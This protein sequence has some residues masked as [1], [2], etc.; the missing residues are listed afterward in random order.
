MKTALINRPKAVPAERAAF[1]GRALGLC[2][3][4]LF[5]AGVAFGPK[6][7]A[8]EPAEP[9]ADGPYGVQ[10]DEE[11]FDP[12]FDAPVPPA[13][14]QDAEEAGDFDDFGEGIVL[15]F[16][17]ASLD[18]VLEYLSEVAGFV[19][20][21]D[22]AVSG[23]VTLMSRQ[24]V[25]EDEAVGLLS[26][27]LKDRGFAAVL[28]GRTLRIV[29]LADAKKT[30]LP[31]SSGSDPDA[32]VPS[33]RIVTHVIP[34][35]FVDAGRLSQDIAGLLP[36]YAELAAN[37]SSNSLILTDTEANIQRIIRIVRALDTH[38]AAVAD[39][40]VFPLRYANATTTARLINEIFQEDRATQQQRSRIAVMAAQRRFRTPQGETG[41]GESPQPQR[42]QASADERTNTVV[43]TGPPDVLEV[44]ERVVEELD[45]NPELEQAVFTYR[46]RHSQSENLA[47]TLNSLF[48]E[49]R[50]RQQGTTTTRTTT[51]GTT[52]RGTTTQ[53]RR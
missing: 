13:P 38:M 4:L 20:I 45:A 24:P 41:A 36:P 2:A 43:V 22:V 32:I 40:K 5:V 16:R 31:V 51:R 53:R 10:E 9:R 28:V 34:L 19:V 8:E 7:S 29:P 46:L 44:V 21:R 52:T 25:T 48:N 6:A 3:A 30:Y 37:A 33:D 35:R 50:A 15:N 18:A 26:T 47:N 42:I 27:V 39:V 17:D 49:M 11:F 12:R 1:T 14:E 23:R